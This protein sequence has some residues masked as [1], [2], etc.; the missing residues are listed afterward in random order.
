MPLSTLAGAVKHK[1]HRFLDCILHRICSLIVVL[2]PAFLAKNIA[3]YQFQVLNNPPR[4][5]KSTRQQCLETAVKTAAESYIRKDEGPLPQLQADAAGQQQPEL[6]Q[7]QHCCHLS[8]QRSVVGSF[9][10]IIITE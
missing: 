9:H 1:K 7:H 8:Q 6:P 10:Q 4:P 3:Q 5:S 2:K